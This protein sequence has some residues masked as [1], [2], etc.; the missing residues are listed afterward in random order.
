MRMKAFILASILTCLS[1][2]AFAHGP[3]ST[4]HYIANEAILVS[5]GET[6]VMFDPLPLSGFGVYPETPKADIAQMMKGEGPYA[7]MTAVFIRLASPRSR[8]RAKYG[9]PRYARRGCDRHP[10]G[11]CR[12]SPPTL[13]PA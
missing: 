10:Y 12:P 4:A 11:R 6:K 8:Y 1:G 2:A 3:S 9:L 7:G 13:H 5:H